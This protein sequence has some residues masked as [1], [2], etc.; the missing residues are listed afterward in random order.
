MGVIHFAGERGNHL[1]LTILRRKDPGAKSW[2]RGN[3]LH[4]TV[5]VNAGAFCGSM[6]SVIFNKDLAE[7]LPDIEALPRRRK[8]AATFKSGDPSGGSGSVYV[9]VYAK[10]DGQGRKRYETQGHLC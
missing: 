7:F 10:V 1:T 9:A 6:R 2:H 3:L 4:C 5:E 8:G